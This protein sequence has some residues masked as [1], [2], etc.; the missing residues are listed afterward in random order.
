MVFGG[1]QLFTLREQYCVCAVC[2]KGSLLFLF[3][4][5]F[6]TP[7]LEKI[8]EPAVITKDNW[9]YL[10]ANVAWVIYALKYLEFA[11]TI[12]FVLRKKSRL[13]TNLHVIHHAALP[14]IAWVFMRTE[15]SG[16]QFFPAGL[17]SFIHIIMYT[18]Y[19]LAAMGPEVRK[20]LWWKE[21]L[22]QLQ[23]LQFVIII[24]FVTVIVPLSGCQTTQHGIYIEI[25]AAII[26]L[27][28]FCN[29]YIQTYKRNPLNETDVGNSKNSNSIHSNW[30]SQL[31]WYMIKMDHRN[32]V[33]I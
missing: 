11:D 14:I 10:V 17:N 3:S 28:L 29:F 25:I 4:L 24:S 30:N 21:Y 6:W 22:T 31:I 12:F 20:Y 16:F 23:M 33:V 26:F 15:T 1:E 18:Y 9:T 32:K 19:G 13:I 5:P 2:E 7:A 8:C 27:A